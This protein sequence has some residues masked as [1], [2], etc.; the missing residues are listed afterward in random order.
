MT[1]M[2]ALILI[3]LCANCAFSQT[4]RAPSIKPATKA[5]K[6]AE[7]KQITINAVGEPLAM[8]HKCS[9]SEGLILVTGIPKALKAESD[10]I[11]RLEKF[12]QEKEAFAKTEDKRIREARE[13]LPADYDYQ[14]PAY[15]SHKRLTKDEEKLYNRKEDKRDAEKELAEAGDK[16]SAMNKLSAINTGTKYAGLSVWKIVAPG[17]APKI[18]AP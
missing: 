13:R 17:L 15:F 2:K 16:F 10:K 7:P 12:I 3:F 8:H 18:S 1:I 4:N 11:A 14:S 9:T 6:P 5:I